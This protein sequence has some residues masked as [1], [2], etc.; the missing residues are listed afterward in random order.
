MSE[1]KLPKYL[2][3]SIAGMSWPQ[4]LIEHGKHD[5]EYW[6]LQT[7]FDLFKA[8]SQIVKQRIDQG[9]IQEPDAQP[10]GLQEEVSTEVLEKLPAQMQTEAKRA[11]AEN[12]RRRRDHAEDQRLWQLALLGL[13]NGEAAWELLHSRSDY[14][15]ERIELVH[16]VV[17]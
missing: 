15:Y 16:P 11:K 1:Y 10:Y 8:A 12:E 3:K 5:R 7:H 13:T 17:P 2:A 14:E 6:L 9:W 4:I